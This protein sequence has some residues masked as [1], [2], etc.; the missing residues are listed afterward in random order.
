MKSA[1]Y[2]VPL[3]LSVLGTAVAAPASG[4]ATQT[5][6]RRNY[7]EEYAD[8]LV[9][10]TACR[11]VTVIYARGTG[12]QGNIGEATDVGPLF[13]DDLAAL[14]G[15]GNL[16]AQGVNYSA[17]V[18]GFELGGDATGS[19]LMAEL[20]TLAYT[21]CPDTQLVLSGY[22]QGGQLVHNAADQISSNVTDF[23]AAVLIFG[24]PDNG[25]AVGDIPDDKVHVICHALDGICLHLGIITPQHLNYQE[26]APAAAEW[27]AAELGY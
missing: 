21:Q 17:D 8:Q 22:S 6:V 2:F 26:D 14:V 11:D 16:A 27:V 19:A 4:S 23:V 5:L 7:T 25:E 18:I 10:G 20:A 24:D 13:L 1:A 9:D 12:Q 3:F 15:S